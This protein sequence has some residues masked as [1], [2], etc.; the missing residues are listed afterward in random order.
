VIKVIG[1]HYN[2]DKKGVYNMN[3]AT[4]HFMVVIGK[5]Y[6]N[7]KAYYRFYD[8]GRTSETNGKAETNLLEIDKTK[9]MI[10]GTYNNKTYTI[11]EIRKKL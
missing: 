2:N 5:I 7:G 4:F 1:V 8:P 10:H 11:T 6:K 9:E 3:K